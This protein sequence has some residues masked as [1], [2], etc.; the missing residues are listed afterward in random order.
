MGRDVYLVD[1]KLRDALT[2]EVY[3]ACLFLCINRQK[4]LF[5]W[6][7]KLAGTDG[8]TNQ[9]YSSALEIAEAAQTQWVKAV[10][11]QSAG[12][13]I[14]HVATGNLGEPEWPKDMTLEEIILDKCFK[15]HYLKDPSHPVLKALRGEV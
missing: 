7:V 13:Y 4:T 6:S 3:P 15:D 9:W 5:V 11:D 12:L 14:A 10:P 1:R 8:R 2:G